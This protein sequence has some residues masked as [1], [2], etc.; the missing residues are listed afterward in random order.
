MIALKSHM[1]LIKTFQKLLQNYFFILKKYFLSSIVLNNQKLYQSDFLSLSFIV[2]FHY[3]EN[4][5]FL[6]FHVYSFTK[7][8]ASVHLLYIYISIKKVNKDIQTIIMPCKQH[9]LG[10]LSSQHYSPKKRY[11][12][13]CLPGIC[14]FKSPDLEDA[15][16]Y[17]AECNDFQS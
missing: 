2:T 14:N 9:V 10:R 4:Y 3:K 8:N 12:N 15:T 5:L 16:N 13:V 7:H 6:F 11:S 1:L 17:K